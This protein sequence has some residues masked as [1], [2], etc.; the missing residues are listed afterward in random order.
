MTSLL[1]Q[2][3]WGVALQ[4]PSRNT[5][6][7]K[8]LVKS[9]MIGAKPKIIRVFGKVGEKYP[10]ISPYNSLG[11]ENVHLAKEEVVHGGILIALTGG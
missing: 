2:G 6:E 1:C 3:P 7:Q 5:S 8:R 4:H 11:A 9:S 10:K